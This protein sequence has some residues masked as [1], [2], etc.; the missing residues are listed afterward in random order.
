M[1]DKSTIRPLTVDDCQRNHI[2]SNTG[3]V[4]D[5]KRKAMNDYYGKLRQRIDDGK[6]NL[7]DQG[8]K[9]DKNEDWTLV[10]VKNN[11]M[12]PELKAEYKKGGTPNKPVSILG[13]VVDLIKQAEGRKGWRQVMEERMN[14]KALPKRFR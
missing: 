2:P 4:M 12:E 5:G 13:D 11:P 8:W 3:V 9:I 7:E 6:N 14:E 1:K 10:G